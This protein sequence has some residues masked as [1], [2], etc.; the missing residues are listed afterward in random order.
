V[1]IVAAAVPL[2][3]VPVR[4]VQRGARGRDLIAVLGGT[5]RLQM[6]YGL[7]VTVGLIAG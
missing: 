2:A 5:G 7:L 4:S 1:A 3:V 6:A